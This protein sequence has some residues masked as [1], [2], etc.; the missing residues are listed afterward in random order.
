MFL[1]DMNFVDMSRITPE[2]TDLHRAHLLG[3]Y[4]NNNLMFGGRKEPRTGGII[5]SSHKDIGDLKAVLEADPFIQSGA[6]EY[7]ITEFTPVM[8]SQPFESLLGG[9]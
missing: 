8:A 6:V 2:L 4:N 7:C 3:E 1:V 5:I 9:G